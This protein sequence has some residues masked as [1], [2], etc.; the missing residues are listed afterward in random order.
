VHE[1]SVEK[2]RIEKG[3]KKERKRKEKGK[4]KERRRKEEGKK[5][6]RR[7]K[8]KGKQGR[9]RKQKGM[10]ERGKRVKQ[11]HRY[12]TTTTRRCTCSSLSNIE[13]KL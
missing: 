12:P 1:R 7:R 6:E 9:S 13:S 11:Q 10:T 2:C 5:K 8:E 4:K 3:K